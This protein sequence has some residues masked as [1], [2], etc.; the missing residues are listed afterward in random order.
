ML[1]EARWMPVGVMS[2]SQE[3]TRATGKPTMATMITTCSASGGN[4]KASK[5]ISETWMTTQATTA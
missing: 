4:S 1:S 5:A 2:Y 3:S